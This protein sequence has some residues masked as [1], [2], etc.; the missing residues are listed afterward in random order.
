MTPAERRAIGAKLMACRRVI[1]RTLGDFGV[2]PEDTDDAVQDVFMTAVRRWKAYRP[3]HDLEGWLHG[4]CRKVAS[5]IRRTKRRRPL[6]FFEMVDLLPDR[7]VELDGLYEARSVLRSLPEHLRPLLAA[8]AEDGFTA[9]A[10]ARGL[11]VE[12]SA[13]GSWPSARAQTSRRLSGGRTVA[14]SPPEHLSPRTR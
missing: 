14:S 4:I 13:C 8:M 5:N 12:L 2:A 6:V 7:S 11:D 10:G 1:E 9:A 3:E